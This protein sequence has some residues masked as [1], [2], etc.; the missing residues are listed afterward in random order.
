MFGHQRALLAPV[1]GSA[2][3]VAHEM[4]DRV[5]MADVDVELVE[6]VAAEILEILLYLNRDIVP[7]RDRRSA[8]PGK[9]GTR[10]K[11]L[12]ER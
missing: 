2:A 8:D 9:L 1:C 3:H 4:H 12:K 7:T 5:A 10:R 6:R 11:R